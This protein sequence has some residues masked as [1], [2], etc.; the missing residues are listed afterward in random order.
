MVDS[1]SV[2][3]TE[4]GVIAGLTP[5]NMYKDGS[6]TSSLTQWVGT[7]DAFWAQSV[8]INL[9]SEEPRPSGLSFT[10]NFLKVIYPR[11]VHEARILY[12]SAQ[13]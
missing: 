10:H 11:R 3:T 7:A 1:Q 13:V 8:S 9:E 5:E 6:T 12:P 4:K 2:K